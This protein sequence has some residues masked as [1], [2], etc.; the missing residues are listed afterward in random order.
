VPGTRYKVTDVII[1][2]PRY[3]PGSTLGVSVGPEHDL[4][5]HGWVEIEEGSLVV[6]IQPDG[7]VGYLEPKE[8]RRYELSQFTGW[9]VS[10]EHLEFSVGSVGG[11]AT[12]GA[13]APVHQGRCRLESQQEAEEL[14]REARANGME[15]PN[16][17]PQ[18]SGI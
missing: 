4:I 17:P 5:G 1:E 16:R 3:S 14:T 12:D 8:K 18:H 15:P 6:A 13:Q 10:G 9:R 2:T 11:F 7:I